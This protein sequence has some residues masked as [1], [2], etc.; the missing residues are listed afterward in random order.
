MRIIIAEKPS[1]AQAIAGVLSGA[2]IAD[3]YIDCAGDTKV[4]WCF[5]HL[6]ET[7]PPEDYVDG[8]KVRPSDLPVIPKE[9]KLTPRDGGA[10]KQVKVIRELLKSAQEV[11][12]AGDADREGQLLVDE[13][14]I[15]L[16]WRGK[17]SRLWLSSLDDESVQRAL[18][19]LKS[20]ESMRPVYDSALG[21]QRADWL[22][23]MNCSIA[24]S[25]NLQAIGVPGAWSI[26]RVQTP[27]LALLVDRMR[28]IEDFRPRDHY[29]VEAKLGDDGIKAQWQIPED[30]LSDG[31]LMDR[32]A[33]EAVVNQASGQSMQVEKFGAKI[34]ERAAPLPYALSTLQK[35]ASRRLGLSARDTLAAAQ[36]LYEARLTTY[37][38]TDC[39]YLPTEMHADAGRILKAI[40]NGQDGLDTERKH[41]AWNT[42]KVEAHHG[43]IPTGQDPENA[44]LS[45]NAKRVFE[46]VRESYVRLFMLPEKFETR[47]AI[48][49]LQTTNGGGDRFRATA[50]I[51]LE[52][53]WTKL[54][55]QEDDED[56]TPSESGKLPMLAEGQTLQ[57]IEATVVAR[58]TAPPKPYTDGTLIAAMTGIHKLVTDQKLKA[59]LKETAGLGTEATRASMIEVLITREYAERKKKEI[60]PT[61]RGVQLIDMLRRVAPELA[62]PG[63]TALQEDA[64]ADIAAG[65]AALDAFLKQETEA[66]RSFSRTLLQGKLVDREIVLHACPACQ[67][68]RCAHLT[69]KAGKPYHRCPDCNAAFADD[70]GRPGKKFEDKPEGADTQKP[71]RKADGP[72]C[73]ACKKATFRYDTKGGKA[74]FRCSEC[75]S[76]WWPDRKDDGKLGTKWEVKSV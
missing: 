38:R 34:G 44:R 10:G 53:G 73:Q 61:G 43:I 51:V 56:G 50:R 30:L 3:G 1:V 11:V 63:T 33:A 68:M 31:L 55:E 49:H 18:A 69:S 20:N 70:G 35:V 26:G 14:L 62:D 21:R 13:V 54:G 46:L 7:A 19:T 32:T 17:T 45:A 67:G 16:A 48:F 71:A 39:P 4:T 52:P 47:E 27:T 41:A 74:Y 29:Q 22:R 28:A 59:R 75:K 76:A 2:K 60:H 9:W 8:G 72:K 40:A 42:G 58:R 65:R 36:E 37:P 23:G 66:V 5:G 25:R 6:L 12:N 57:C 64:L 15:H 24:I